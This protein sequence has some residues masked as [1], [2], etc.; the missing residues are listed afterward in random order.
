SAI[1]RIRETND[2]TKIFISGF[3]LGATFAALAAARINGEGI[4][5]II[6]LD[7]YLLTPPDLDP[8]Y[9]ERT[10]TPNWFADDLESH[11]L[12]YKRWIKILQDVIDD[13]S[14]PDFLPV[15]IFDNRAQALAHFLYANANFGGQGGLSNAQNGWADIQALARVLQSQDRYWPR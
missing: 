13:P 10:P 4:A 2:Q 1:Q 12:P 6:L 7:G 14:G 11:F 3:G 15:P 8:L 5:G 9:R